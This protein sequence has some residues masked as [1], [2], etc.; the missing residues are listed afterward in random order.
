MTSHI[1]ALCF[2]V[3]TVA[4]VTI[5]KYSYATQFREEIKIKGKF[6]STN[7]SG[8]H[9]FLVFD[10]RKYIY[11]IRSFETYTNFECKET[12]E[13]IGYGW[14][15]SHIGVYPTITMAKRLVKEIE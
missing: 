13:I 7:Y 5:E 8:T 3:A 9:R 4:A 12:Y 1:K 6:V 14:N 15:L 11:N 10:K 2:T